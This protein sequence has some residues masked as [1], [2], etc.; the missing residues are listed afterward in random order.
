M[1][2]HA[3]GLVE[4]EEYGA[5]EAPSANLLLGDCGMWSKGDKLAFLA[6]WDSG[7]AHSARSGLELAVHAATAMC[8]PLS[9]L[10]LDFSED[11]CMFRFLI[12][13]AVFEKGP[14][15]QGLDFTNTVLNVQEAFPLWTQ[16]IHNHGC[17]KSVHMLENPAHHNG[18]G[19][20]DTWS[21]VSVALQC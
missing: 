13:I 3:L 2:G 11:L 5:K 18:L 19:Y 9:L 15:A 6:T 21:G 10:R 8:F 16:S 4:A 20:V 14:L 17:K 1:H 12:A 7:D